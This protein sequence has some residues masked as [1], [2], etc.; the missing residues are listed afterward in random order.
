[1]RM[2]GSLRSWLCL[3]VLTLINRS[4]RDVSSG[5]GVAV[6]G[7]GGVTASSGGTGPSLSSESPGRGPAT[8][9]APAWYSSRVPQARA[10]Q[11]NT[12]WAARRQLLAPISLVAQHARANKTIPHDTK[13]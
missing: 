5:L 10:R 9:P 13:I 8:G 1:M 12:L 3:V 11:P 2:M 7:G 4:W 6:A